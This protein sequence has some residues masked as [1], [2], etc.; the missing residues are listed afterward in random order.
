MDWES[1][2]TRNPAGS[3]MYEYGK[4]LAFIFHAYLVTLVFSFADQANPQYIS[5]KL[6][7]GENYRLA[8][9]Y[10]AGIRRIGSKV[11]RTGI[12]VEIEFILRCR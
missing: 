3:C 11:S 5:C 8:L 7:P 4:Y 1:A 6:L 9:G 12:G 2:A 10:L